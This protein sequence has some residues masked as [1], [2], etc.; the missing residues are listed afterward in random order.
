M[1]V[2]FSA[3]AVLPSLK[4]E[5]ALTDSHGAVLTSAVSVGFVAGTLCSALLGLAD[6]IDQRRFFAAACVMAAVANAGMLALEPGSAWVV[7]LR[8]LV[9]ASAA[10]I[11]PVGMRM[12]AA[13]A[14]VDMGLLVGALVGAQVLGLAS[15]HLI[16]ALGGFDWRV[17]LACASALAL[18]AGV[19]VNAVSLG[20]NLVRPA[21]FRARF[22]M[23][24][25]R[26]KSI[27][28]ANIG[29]LGHM[30]ELFAMWGWIGLFLVASFEHRPGGPDAIWWA[31]VTAFASIAMGAPGCLIGGFLADRY[32]RTTVTIGAL[33]ISGACSVAVGGFYGGDPLILTA[34]CLIWG[35]AVV[36]D[37]PQ[38][39]ASVA[40]LSEPQ[41]VGTMITIQTC[42]GFL[43][44]TATIQLVPFLVGQMG[45]SYTFVVLAAGPAVGIVAMLRLRRHPDAVRLA[46]GNR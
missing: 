2:W 45:W 25:W 1:T 14:R 44:T 37:S 12:V 18:A 11:Y 28:L 7:M 17:T 38:F 46:N 27:R 21:V 35:A 23:N 26:Q 5:F 8:F 34:I 36:A 33:A 30:W 9:G 10:G 40:E 19:L 13:W 24:A 16:D 42:A 3:S 20:P 32:G 6:R 43:L 39:T 29:Y 22:V 31:K 41:L 4:H 15:P